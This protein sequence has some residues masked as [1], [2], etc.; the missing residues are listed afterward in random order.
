M[1]I[2]TITNLYSPHA[3][4]EIVKYSQALLRRWRR[5][6]GERNEVRRRRRNRE[7]F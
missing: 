2:A 5:W 6:R 1:V 4:V 7:T 3:G